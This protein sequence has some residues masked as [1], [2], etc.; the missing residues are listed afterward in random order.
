MNYLLEFVIVSTIFAVAGFGAGFYYHDKITRW[1]K[2][3][4][5]A[6]KEKL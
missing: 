4:K 3:R 6:L 2:K 5:A 1:I